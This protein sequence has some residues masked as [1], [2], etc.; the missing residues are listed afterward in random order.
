MKVDKGFLYVA[1]G[2]EYIREAIRSA[3]SLRQQMPDAKITLYSDRSLNSSLFDEIRQLQDPVYHFG[4]SVLTAEM[5]PYGRTIYVD[6]DTYFTEG[7]SELFEILD[8]FDIAAVHNPARRKLESTESYEA[9]EV[10]DSFPQYNTGVLVLERNQKVAEMLAEWNQIYEEH[11]DDGELNQPSFR[12][13]LYHSNLDIA[14]LP[15]EYNCRIP[16]AGYLHGKAKI[17]HGHH[18]EIRRVD[19]KLNANTGMRVFTTRRWPVQVIPEKSSLWW[20]LLFSIKAQGW[21]RTIQ[22]AIQKI[23]GV[24]R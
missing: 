12:E 4:D 8:R 17:L 10:P 15:S 24:F 18:P 9:K 13:A 22:S 21:R 11:L 7:V 16:R 19:Q 6:T 1:T 3:N 2:E 23:I 5:L 20:R 14:T